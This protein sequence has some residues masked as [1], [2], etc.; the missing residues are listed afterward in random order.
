MAIMTPDRST[1][2]LL[3]RYEQL[4]FV[5]RARSSDVLLATS[6]RSDALLACI[7]GFCKEGTSKLVET[8]QFCK[9]G[10]SVS[11]SNTVRLHQQHAV[12]S[13]QLR[14]KRLCKYECALC[15]HSKQQYLS[16]ACTENSF[17]SERAASA[18]ELVHAS[19]R[20]R[21]FTNSSGL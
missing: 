12:V 18:M 15:Y 11:R 9:A 2:L 1:A 16:T 10:L 19:R 5:V 4:N 20:A 3:C 13:K 6:I 17:V 8:K 21:T 14:L 7:W